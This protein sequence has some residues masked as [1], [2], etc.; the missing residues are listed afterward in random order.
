MPFSLHMK[1]AENKYKKGDCVSVNPD[2]FEY[3]E[4]DCPRLWLKSG[5]S[6][7]DW[8][9]TFAIINITD[10]NMTGQ[11]EEVKNL[12]E[13]YG[14]KEITTYDQNGQN[15]K[16]EIVIDP[17]A[18]FARRYFIDLPQDYNH[19][20]RKELRET[21]EAQTTWSVIKPYITRRD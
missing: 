13:P 19:P 15:P 5:R 8:R 1:Y 4:G 6:L 18:P 7:Q 2:G 12:I 9:N 21:G 14:F 16:Q 3:A 20:V 17:E 11:E 10:T